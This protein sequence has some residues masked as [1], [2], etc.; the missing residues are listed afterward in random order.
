MQ[1]I[2]TRVKETKTFPYSHL[3]TWFTHISD[4]TQYLL[5]TATSLE[6]PDRL[7]TLYRRRPF[8]LLRELGIADADIEIVISVNQISKLNGI[9]PNQ[10]TLKIPTDLRMSH[11]KDTFE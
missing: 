3:Q 4:H 5:E 11:V 10:K 7:F 2:T 8:Y 1:S 6:I 9:A